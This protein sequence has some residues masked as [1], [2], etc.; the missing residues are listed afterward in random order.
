MK[1]AILKMEGVGLTR[2]SSGAGQPSQPI[3][4]DISV[5]ICESSVTA[6][7]GPSGAGKSSLL[8]LLN[9]LEDPTS[10]TIIYR[11]KLL[12]TYPVRQIRRKIGMVFQLPAL[13]PGT[14]RDNLQ[15]GPFLWG[16]KRA[17][18]ELVTLLN[19]VDLPEELLNRPSQ[20]LSVG[21]Q[22]RVS[23]ARTLANRPEVLLLDEPTS[24]L[25]PTTAAH[26]LKLLINLK[27]ELGITIVFVTHLLEQAK[28]I[29]DHVLLLAQGKKITESDA[30]SFFNS[31]D[32]RIIAFLKGEFE[33]GDADALH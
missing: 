3:L 7:L 27:Q 23:I 16:E 6:V 8:R 18:Q 15:Y 29:A 13:F 21:Q 31:D 11:E 4:M 17:D 32:P 5:S 33:S 24:G 28:A 10:G 19:H 26:I 22:Q 14:V 25:D 9:R 12:S 20:E 1:I 2:P 30:S